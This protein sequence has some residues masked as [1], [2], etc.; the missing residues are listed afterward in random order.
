MRRS[1][2][3]SLSLCLSLAP[4]ALLGGCPQT[5]DTGNNGNTTTN[6]PSLTTA[7][8]QSA[9]TGLNSLA[10][11][12]SATSSTQSAAGGDAQSALDTPG[13]QILGT[14]PQVTLVPLSGGVNAVSFTTNIDFGSGCYPAGQAGQHTYF[15]SGSATG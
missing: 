15:V 12:A 7:E 13:Q 4:L 5:G 1:T 3:F 14:C 11:L 10:S 8:Q 6:S 9:D 2:R